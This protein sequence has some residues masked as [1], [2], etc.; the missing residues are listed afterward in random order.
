LFEN[1]PDTARVYSFTCE[2]EDRQEFTAGKARLLVGRAKVTFEIT[3]NSD[4]LSFGV[5]HL[6]D[7]NI[8]CGVRIY[9]GEKAYQK[10]V[11]EMRDSFDRADFSRNHP[12]HGP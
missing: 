12:A 5:L 7:H 2:R 6:G 11:Q 1:Y 4:V 9:Q 3:R 8:N 10:L